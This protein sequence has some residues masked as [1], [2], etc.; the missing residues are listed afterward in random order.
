[1]SEKTA[2]EGGAGRA[3]AARQRTGCDC[4]W[5]HPLHPFPSGCFSARRHIQGG[6]YGGSKSRL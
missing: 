1:M 6:F 4:G 2:F 5:R 3:S